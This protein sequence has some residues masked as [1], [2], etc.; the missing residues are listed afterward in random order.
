MYRNYWAGYHS[1]D[2]TCS[3]GVEPFKEEY[4]SGVVL[5]RLLTQQII[6]PICSRDYK[7]KGINFYT[8]G[9]LTKFFFFILEGR[10]EVKIGNDGLIFETRSYTHFGA[11]A[12]L[13]TLHKPV[14]E[15]RPDFSAWP[16]TDCQVVIITQQQYIAICKASLFE[17]R[18]HLVESK[19][20]EVEGEMSA[21]ANDVFNDEWA[22]AESCDLLEVSRSDGSGGLGP[23]SRFLSKSSSHG[24]HKHINNPFKDRKT[25][26]QARLLSNSGSFV[27]PS[28]VEL[29]DMQQS[30]E[31]TAHSDDIEMD[32]EKNWSRTFRTNPESST[33]SSDNSAKHRFTQV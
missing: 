29:Q 28:P 22:K 4:V 19:R 6:F 32:V 7:S 17:K 33:D 5:Q 16:V 31:H 2:D 14:P 3:A 27:P 1:S 15:Y 13:N 9:R 18:K 25:S 23:I 12:L 8:T 21:E 26:D 20:K 10:M 11:Q 24:E 30:R